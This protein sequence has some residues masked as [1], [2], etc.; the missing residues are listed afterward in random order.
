MPHTP[1]VITINETKLKNIN[2]HLIFIE[3]Y[4]F[5]SDNSPTNCGRIGFYL[6]TSLNYKTS[7]D[8]S[9]NENLVEDIWVEIIPNDCNKPYIVGG[10]YFYRHSSIINVQ[11]KFEHT[12]KN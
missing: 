2:F 7:P 4:N 1:E 6:H 5:H 3:N 11:L 9:L 8:L 12:K 10:I